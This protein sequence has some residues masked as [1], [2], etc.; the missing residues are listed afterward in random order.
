M[1]GLWRPYAALIYCEA[2]HCLLLLEVDSGHSTCQAVVCSCRGN[3]LHDTAPVPQD[4]AYPTSRHGPVV[5]HVTISVRL[6]RHACLF[7]KRRRGGFDKLLRQH[8]ETVSPRNTSLFP[9]QPTCFMTLLQETVTR[10]EE[11]RA[12]TAPEFAFPRNC[13]WKEAFWRYTRGKQMRGVGCIFQPLLPAP[14]RL[15]DHCSA[16]PAPR[17]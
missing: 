14:S 12:G 9:R 10:R 7:N 17:N 5:G 2:C 11:V 1:S 15:L 4:T 8:G 6:A 16:M 13:T 3:Q